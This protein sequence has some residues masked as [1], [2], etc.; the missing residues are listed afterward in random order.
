MIFSSHCDINIIPFDVYYL[1]LFDLIHNEYVYAFDDVR[2]MRILSY[3]REM[4]T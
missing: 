1:F 2:Y 4:P 3:V